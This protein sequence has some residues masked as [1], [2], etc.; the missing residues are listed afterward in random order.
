MSQFVSMPIEEWPVAD[1]QMWEGLVAGDDPMSDAGALAHLR[2]VSQKGL[3]KCYGRWLEWLYRTEPKCLAS[4]PAL[5]ATLERLS[6]WT[7]DLASVAP[8]TRLTL[9]NGALQVLREAYPENDWRRPLRLLE[10]LRIEVRNWESPRKRGRVVSSAV[11]LEVAIELFAKADKADDPVIAA[12]MRRD[13]TMIAFLT[14]VPIR[15][16]AF[17]ELTLG[18]SV[19]ASPTRI[20]IA[21]S[22]DMT[23]NGLP[24][25]AVVPQPLDGM[26]R[27]YL[28]DTRTF[29]I[30]HAGTRHDALWVTEVGSPMAYGY[31]KTRIPDVTERELG[32][33]ISPHLFRD[34]AVTTLVRS[35]PED[36][37]LTRPLLAHASYGIVER[38][39]NHAKGIEA[40]RDYAAVIDG[41]RK[42]E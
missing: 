31:I 23:K 33:R 28:C 37:R 40:G 8:P 15:L 11:V 27:T 4:P 34:M 10:P 5:R 16:R 3:I 26:L 32:I 19:L 36:A 18:Q 2:E 25:E 42:K 14:M 13:G 17:S 38:H 30:A 20:Q 7:A 29:L 35:S 22:E 41:L 6:A 1:R 39:Y 21:L 9:V 12:T 24:W